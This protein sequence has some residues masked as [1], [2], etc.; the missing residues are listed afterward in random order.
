MAALPTN[1]MIWLDIDNS[2]ELY[3][4]DP[5]TESESNIS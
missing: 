5:T 3:K 1:S 2:Y 4:T